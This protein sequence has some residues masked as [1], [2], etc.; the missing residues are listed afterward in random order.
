G[1]LLGRLEERQREVLRPRLLGGR[2]DARRVG[3]EIGLVVGRIDVRGQ[4]RVG[5]SRRGAGGSGNR[6]EQGSQDGQAAG[7]ATADGHQPL[8]IVR[9][10]CRSWERSSR[11]R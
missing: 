3:G 11:T 7:E 6:Q 2:G 1:A 4:R 5:G 9:P 8:P 10:V